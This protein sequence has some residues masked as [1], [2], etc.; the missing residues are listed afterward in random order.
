MI[1]KTEAQ[2]IV[3]NYPREF[4]DRTSPDGRTASLKRLAFLFCHPDFLLLPPAIHPH[5]SVF[6]SRW[7][8]LTDSLISMLIFLYSVSQYFWVPTIC[9]ALF[10][11]RK[12]QHWTKQTKYLS[13]QNLV[14]TNVCA[15]GVQVVISGMRSPY[16]SRLTVLKPPAHHSSKLSETIISASLQITSSSCLA[17]AWRKFD[18]FFFFKIDWLILNFW[19]CW[20]FVAV[21]G[22]SQVVVSGACVVVLWFLFFFFLKFY[23]IFF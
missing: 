23:F 15:H 19:L 11:G 8:S 5:G 17:C 21:P 3:E 22:L 1:K 10:Y 12:V 2:K 6:S 4:R 14:S 16:Q 9:P 13:S 7:L 20:V 18:S